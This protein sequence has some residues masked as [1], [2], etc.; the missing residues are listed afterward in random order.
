[1][2]NIVPHL[3]FDKEARELAEYYTTLFPN[4][5]ITNITTISGTPSGDVDIIT[6]NLTGVKFMAI[7]AGPLFRINASTSFFV[8]CG[9]EMDIDNLYSK[10]SDGGKIL[11]PL[12]KYD[13]SSKYAWVED[14]YGLSWQLD[15]DAVN[16]PQKIVPAL[17]FTHDKAGK[18][19]EAIDFYSSVFP[20]SKIL[21]ESPFEEG[22]DMHAGS[23][24]FA[25][26]KLSGYLFNMMGSPV[27][28]GFDF[29]EAVSYMI[30]CGTQE[31]IDYYWE[32]LTAG[33][34]EQPCGWV[35]DRFGVSWQ[36][37]PKEM[38]EMMAT[39]DKNQL[40]RVTNEML[41]MKKIDIVK[42]RKA[43]NIEEHE[44]QD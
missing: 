13:W 42:L 15:V 23:L 14:K 3:W 4:S 10:L 29:N 33:G 24:L 18:I 34:Q 7:S 21:L 2:K 26:V 31:E 12:G 6:F 20:E 40:D 38:D 32:N 35:K 36:V 41:K 39:K 17:L 8:Y 27:N 1:M 37:V 5:E 44:I 25:Q 43:Y 19:K 22:T 9:A 28:H 11:M 16:S 30:Y